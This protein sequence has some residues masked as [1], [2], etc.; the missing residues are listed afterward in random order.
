VDALQC[1]YSAEG[2]CCPITVNSAE[3]AEKL[4]VLVEQI[5]KACG[6]SQCPEIPCRVTPSN[7]CEPLSGVAPGRCQ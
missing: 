5:L 4:E 2:P 1:Q 7:H 3:S 6:P